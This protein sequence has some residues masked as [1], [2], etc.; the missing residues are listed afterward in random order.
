[1]E[2]KIFQLVVLIELDYLIFLW[3]VV[4]S[5]CL[6][7]QTSFGLRTWGKRET[8]RFMVGTDAVM[9]RNT[10]DFCTYNY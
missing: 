3:L 10:S 7:V 2:N 4:N 1:M 9:A 6:K 5:L 8:N